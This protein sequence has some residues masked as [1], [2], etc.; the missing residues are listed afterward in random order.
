MRQP[1]IT[2]QVVPIDAPVYLSMAFTLMG[3]CDG[4]EIVYAETGGIPG[5]ITKENRHVERLKVRLGLI[6]AVA[7]PMSASEKFVRATLEGF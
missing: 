1:N 5:G 6:R 7:L 2:V 3:F 4:N